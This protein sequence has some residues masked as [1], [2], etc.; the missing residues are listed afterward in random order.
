MD[1]IYEKIHKWIPSKLDEKTNDK[2][3]SAFYTFLLGINFS[4]LVN[5]F[6]DRIKEINYDFVDGAKESGAL[7]FFGSIIMSLL[8]LGYINNIDNLFTFSSCYIL[9]DHYIDDDTIEMKDKINTIKQL[10]S[11]IKLK[12]SVSNNPIIQAISDKYIEMITLLP[13]SEP[14]LKDLFDIEIKT[15]L[16]QTKDNLTRDEYLEICESKGGI[17]CLAIQSLLE[18]KITDDEYNLGACIQLVDDILDIDDD[19][20]TRINTI[21]TYDYKKYNNIDNLIV[22]TINRIDNMSSK[23]NMFKIILIIEL[24]LAVHINRDKIS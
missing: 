2:I 11:F 9:I 20:K 1:S 18:L 24:I 8:Q 4:P 10:N 3:I 13:K 23:Y 16:L 21:A 17:T 6:N 7:C 5:N 12:T 14:Y 19:I 15:M 22:Y